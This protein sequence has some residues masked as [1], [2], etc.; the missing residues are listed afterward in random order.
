MT[1][2]MP[3][4]RSP[5][6]FPFTPKNVDYFRKIALAQCFVKET[7]VCPFSRAQAQ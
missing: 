6:E 7:D 1:G 2:V 5:Y 4:M 3:E